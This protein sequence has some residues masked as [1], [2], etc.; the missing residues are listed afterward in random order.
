[1]QGNGGIWSWTRKGLT[2]RMGLGRVKETEVQTEKKK[3]TSGN[4]Q[5]SVMSSFQ[6]TNLSTFEFISQLWK[7]GGNV[8]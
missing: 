2:T 8:E 1:M 5:L 6:K 3:R 7:C 4:Y